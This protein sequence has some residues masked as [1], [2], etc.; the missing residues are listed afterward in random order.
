M[1]GSPMKFLTFEM[2]LKS[3]LSQSPDRRSSIPPFVHLSKESSRHRRKTYVNDI[4]FEIWWIWVW[5]RI[6]PVYTTNMKLTWT[7]STFNKLMT[8]I[9]NMVN[10]IMEKNFTWLYYKHEAYLDRVYIQQINEWLQEGMRD[11]YRK[12]RITRLLN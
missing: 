9:W 4:D 1:Y 2:Y 12:W 7:G 10:M 3:L 8:L 11:Y 6:L 5:K